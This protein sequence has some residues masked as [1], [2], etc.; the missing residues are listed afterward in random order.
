MLSTPV[1]AFANVFGGER[2]AFRR[3][4]VRLDEVADRLAE[5]GA[6]PVLVRAARSGRDA[7][8][9]R[10]QVLVG[11]FRPLQHEIEPQRRRP[12]SA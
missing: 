3:Q 5:A 7:V 9:V 4:V 1:S 8:D 10:A 2:H 12:W 11:A 6:Q